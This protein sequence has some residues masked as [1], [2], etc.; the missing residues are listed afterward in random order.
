MDEYDKRTSVERSNKWEKDDYHL[1]DGRHRSAKIWYCRLY[2]IM[3][4]QHLNAWE[5]PSIEDFQKDV[6]KLTA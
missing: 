2:V 5:I 4:C 6:L 1:E 3:M